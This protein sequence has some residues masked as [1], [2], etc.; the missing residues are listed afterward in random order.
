MEGEDMKRAVGL[1]VFLVLVGAM[2]CVCAKEAETFTSGDYTYILN[3]DGSAVITSYTGKAEKLAIPS[4]LDGHTVKGIGNYAFGYCFSLTSISLPDSITTI[5]DNAFTYCSLT[6]IAL[7]DSITILGTNPW[8]GCKNLDAINISPNH[9]SLTI[10]DRVLCSK[11]DKRLVWYPTTSKASNFEIP[12]GIQSIGDSAFSGCDSLTTITMPDSVTTIGKFAFY[13]CNSL[14]TITLSNSITTIGDAAFRYCDNL[15]SV[16]LP[17]SLTTIG[18]AAFE[19]CENL[20]SIILPDSITT[21]GDRAFFYCIKLT[22]ITLPDSITDLGVNPWLRC[23]NLATI[24]V[25]RNHPSLAVIDGALYSKTD[26]RLV[27]YSMTS[28]ASTFEVPNG[29]RII[30]NFAFCY[31]RSLTSI[32]LPESVTT[33]GRLAFSDCDNLTFIVPE[34]SYAEQYCIDNNLTYQFINNLDWLND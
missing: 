30:D 1:I 22:T 17:D 28:K 12:E 10:I 19:G 9:P 7:P 25:S 18:E 5:G 4:E 21:I 33:I 24:N 14:T 15:T 3:E 6:T 23:E 26:K 20:T 27:W 11:D 2:L 31:C 32:T 34:G 29:I 8:K 13:E 16:T